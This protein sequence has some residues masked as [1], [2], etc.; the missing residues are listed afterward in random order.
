MAL[1]NPNIP[2]PDPFQ[3]TGLIQAMGN[4]RQRGQLIEYIKGWQ[5][6]AEAWQETAEQNLAAFHESDARGLRN[7]I[8]GSAWREKAK[9]LGSQ[10]GITEQDL[11]NSIE[12]AYQ[13]YLAAHPEDAEYI[14]QHLSS[15]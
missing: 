13:E 4:A 8:K 7:F 6:A 15:E 3:D 1:G 14:K 12:Q 5:G 9:E 11:E 2:T 10:L